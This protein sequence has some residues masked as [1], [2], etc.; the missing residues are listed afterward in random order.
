MLSQLPLL[1][2]DMIPPVGQAAVGWRISVHCNSQRAF[3]AGLVVEYDPLTGMHSVAYG[4]PARETEWMTLS[5]QQV[6]HHAWGLLWHAA[7]QVQGSLHVAE[8]LVHAS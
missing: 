5:Q 6:G 4:E 2:A 3:C 7:L 8:Q 1:P